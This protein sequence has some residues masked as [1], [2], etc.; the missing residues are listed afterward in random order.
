MDSTLRSL[1]SLLLASASLLSAAPLFAA[2]PELNP[3]PASAVAPQARTGPMLEKGMTE[4]QIIAAIGH[5][6]ETRPMKVPGGDDHKAETWVYRRNLGTR[7]VQVATGTRSVPAF[8]GM[9]T[10][11]DTTGTTQEIIYT[12][13]HI[14]TYSVTWLLM[15]DGKLELARQ[16]TEQEERF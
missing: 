4:A 1:P 11:N 15:I 8:K 2:A 7:Q 9:G 3:A 6:A 16:T 5:P 13:K 10:G 12:L 14:T